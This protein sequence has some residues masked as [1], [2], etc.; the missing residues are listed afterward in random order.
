MITKDNSLKTIEAVFFDLDGLLADT[1][2]V[3]YKSYNIVA[4]HLGI[5][6]SKKYMRAF[7]GVATRENI[8]M[9]IKDFNIKDHRYEDILKLR[10]DSYHSL[11]KETPLSPM[12]GAEVCIE[13]I[14]ACNLK[15]GLVTSSMKNHAL[16][17]LK[18]ISRHFSATGNLAEFF[19]V[20]VFGSEITH[21]KPAPDIYTEAVRRLNID[22]AKCAALEDSEA[23]VI[24]AKRAGLFVVAVPNQHT[25]GQNFGM[26]DLSASSLLDVAGMDFLN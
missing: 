20:M 12:E 21:L 8:K 24:S 22:P 4:G 2:D 13:K 25:N 14:M 17:V 11:I 7:Y 18:N 26:A 15:S 1:E 3:H 9:I 10:Y 23:G 6:L 19:N 5:V 16:T